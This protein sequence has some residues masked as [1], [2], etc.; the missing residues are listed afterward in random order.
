MHIK[1]LVCICFIFYFM[2]YNYNNIKLVTLAVAG[3][4]IF[5]DP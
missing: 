4:L 2:R 1:R 5:V 3:L